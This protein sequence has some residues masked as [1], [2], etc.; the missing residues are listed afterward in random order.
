MT[1]ITFTARKIDDAAKGSSQC[2]ILPLYHRKK[3][4][5]EAQQAG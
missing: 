3:L 4:S 1:A 5:R 2:V